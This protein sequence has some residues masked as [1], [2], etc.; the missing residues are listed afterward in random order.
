M[1]DHLFKG[2]HI[3]TIPAIPA[4]ATRFDLTPEL[5]DAGPRA[6]WHVT[7][8]LSRKSIHLRSI[9]QSPTRPFRSEQW[10][11][12]GDG[13]RGFGDTCAGPDQPDAV[14]PA[15]TPGL[16]IGDHRRGVGDGDRSALL[17]PLRFIF[18]F[19][20]MLDS[21]KA[22]EGVVLLH[23]LWRTSASMAKV[24]GALVSAG[25]VVL[26]CDYPSRTQPIEQLSLTVVGRA[27]ADERLR[28]C[29][30]VHFVT[31]SLG[32][33]LVRYYF[34]SRKEERLGRVVMLGP[35]NQGSE[36]VDCL[37]GWWV[38]RKANGP[39]GLQLGSDKDSVPNQLG[40]VRFELGVIAGDRSINW[41]NSCMIRGC[42][43]GKVSVEST[44]I[45]GMRDHLIIHT[46]HPFMMKNRR[47]ITSIIAFLKSGQ[48]R[49]SGTEPSAATNGAEVGSDLCI[50]PLTGRDPGE[51]SRGAW[52]DHGGSNEWAPGII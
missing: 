25:Y 15:I 8:A 51:F 28:G 39:A 45:D 34:A 41:I 10:S 23:G 43:D 33:I 4:C 18:L 24:E 47:V 13:H 16:Q 42:D 36:V 5:S 44:K 21:V 9:I 35:P 37:R 31:H 11:I 6:F 49:R 14:N 3:P 52:L 1:P 12:A 38:F 32:G 7:R 50:R 29:S 40:P 26:N 2:D 27:L 20:M 22:A 46:T 30:K 48:F 19:F 17:L